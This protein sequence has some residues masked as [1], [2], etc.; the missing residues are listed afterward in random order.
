ME[1]MWINYP[2]YSQNKKSWN[3]TI[4]RIADAAKN[5]KLYE[6]A[7]VWITK[8]EIEKISALEN[9]DHQCVAFTM[10]CLAKLETMRNQI[11]NG[12]IKTD[13]KEIFS[14]AGV[15]AS[16]QKRLNILG[17]LQSKGFLEFPKKNGNLSNRVTFMDFE[18]DEEIFVQD[19]RSIGNAYRKYIGENYIQCA[20]C[21]VL[22]KGS[23]N[24]RKK[25]CSE[26]NPDNV[27]KKKIIFCIDC[28]KRVEIRSKD[29]YTCRCPDCYEKYRKIQRAEAQKKRRMKPAQTGIKHFSSSS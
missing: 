4:E 21:G 14:L 7:G 19:F 3:E 11:K 15:N 22:V 28:G 10:L 12:W 16:A 2:T 9:T 27:G 6:D 18:A 29:N 8:T 25:Y 26:C 5:E 13:I 20:V 23:K 1:F 24:G 17:M